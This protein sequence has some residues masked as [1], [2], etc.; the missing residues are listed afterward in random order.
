VI[1]IIT[2]AA[3]IAL[4]TSAAML[5]LDLSGVF[6]VAAIVAPAGIVYFC[7]ATIW[8][9]GYAACLARFPHAGGSANALVSGLFIV[10]S[11]FFMLIASS[12][13]SET[14]WPLWLLYTFVSTGVFVAFVGF[15]RKEFDH[16]VS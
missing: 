8:P 15:L 7:M 4:L 12:L 10:V 6:S 3:G 11:A 1:R 2:T 14:A 9:N 13:N 5:A 16:K